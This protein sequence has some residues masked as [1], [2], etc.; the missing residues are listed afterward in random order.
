M[1]SEKFLS[2]KKI[3]SHLFKNNFLKN[4][5]KLDEQYSNL[6]NIDNKKKDSKNKLHI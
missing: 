4:V 5:N 2:S 3:Y 6:S 1:F